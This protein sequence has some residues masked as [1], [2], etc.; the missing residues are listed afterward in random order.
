MK[1]F[2]KIL[3][4]RGSVPVSGQDFIRYG[5]STICIFVRLDDQPVILDAGTGLMQAGTVLKQEERSVPILLSHPHVDHLMGLPLCPLMFDRSREFLIYGEA[6]Q[7]LDPETQVRRLMSPPL[8]PVG[9][10]ALPASITF[11][12]ISGSFSVGTVSVETMAGSHPG[13]VTLFRLTGGGKRVVYLS[14]CTLEGDRMQEAAEFARGCDLLLCDGQYTVREWPACRTFGHNTWEMA[15]D[16]GQMC[17]AKKT[18]IFH[19]APNRTDAQMDEI[20]EAL[21]RQYPNCTL[22]YE[23]E[24][25]LL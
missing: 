11:Q 4:A 6:H 22:A 25:I 2:V 15:A 3:G 9:P 20:A 16:L 7:G 5:G 24:E 13:G 10:E 1:D 23:G 12:E 17:G 19:H 21:A 14:D 8:W 18:L